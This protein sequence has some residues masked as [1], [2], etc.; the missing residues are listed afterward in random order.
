MQDE[1]YME[2]ALQLAKA[3]SG[4]TGPNPPV[5]AV[6]IKNGE[7][8]G[9]GAHLKAGDAHAEVYALQMAGEKAEGATIYVTLEPCSHIGKTLPC[10]DLIIEKGIHR[11]VVAACDPNEKVS[12]RGIAK[13]RGA[14]VHVDVGVLEEKAKQINQVFFHY[15]KTGLPFVT[16]KAATSLDGKTATKTGDSK[17]IT[18]EKSR[19]DGRRYRQLHDAIL[20][21]VETVLADNPRL[22][23]RIGKNGKN[24][25]RVILDT[26]LR[27]PIEANIVTD[28][29]AKTLI[30]TGKDIANDR[31][32]AFS[33]HEQVR[34]IPLEEKHV[35]ILSVLHYLG[36][37]GMMSLLV[38]GGATVH[39]SFLASGQ[40]DRLILYMAPLLIGGEQAPTSFA[41]KGF[42]QL[43]DAN[44]LAVEGLEWIG[45]D[46]KIIAT[47]RKDDEDVHGDC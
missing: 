3:A 2:F 35:P 36:D 29:Q 13:L 24:P 26:A 9:F 28:Q 5:G 38:E 7:I 8:A 17:W 31:I 23:S 15:I 30:F 42:Q 1:E 4:Q 19:F 45:R 47:P 22:T 10:T 27:T 39:G 32:A 6:V 33:K 44:G 21:G 41:G 14:G 34:V 40:W 12:G 11:V 46:M 25:V 16:L 20:V 43:K 37:K 18:G